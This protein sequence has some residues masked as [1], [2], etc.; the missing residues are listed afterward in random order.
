MNQIDYQP[1]TAPVT[2]E[3]I[4]NYKDSQSGGR[5]RRTLQNSIII[6]TVLAI[7]VAFISRLWSLNGSNPGSFFSS[8]FVFVA[9]ISAGFILYVVLQDQQ[10]IRNFKIER[11]AKVNNFNFSPINTTP[12]KD[13]I[14]FNVGRSHTSYEILN[15]NVGNEF[16]LANHRYVVGSGKDSKVIERG[17]LMIRLDR[18][19]PNMVLDSKKN[20]TNIFGVSISNLPVILNKK[21]ILSLEGD[22]DSHF[23]LYAPNDYERDALYIFTPDLMALFID[24]SGDF[25]AEIIDDKLY[26]YSE[27]AFDLLNLETIKRLFHII[28]TVMTKA[29]HR[30]KNYSDSKVVD[31]YSQSVNQISSSGQRLKSSLSYAKLLLIIIVVLYVL[32]GIVNFFITMFARL[33]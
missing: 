17:Y 8:V 11:F 32:L 13:G 5:P 33:Y 30:S 7:G 4:R 2:R 9:L 20:N 26:I 3:E 29:V 18:K 19:L 23:T 1:L 12:E 24:K 10:I 14:M 6:I 31:N 27:K 15:G 21:Q 16:E 22:F 28:G 25:D